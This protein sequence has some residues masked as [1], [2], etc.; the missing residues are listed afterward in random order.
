VH[1]FGLVREQLAAAR[2]AGLPFEQAWEAVLAS[3]PSTGSTLTDRYLTSVALRETME[4]W[5]AAY[6]RRP[7][8][9][10]ESLVS[11]PPVADEIEARYLGPEAAR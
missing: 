2:R 1:E 4:A 8:P 5:K 6:E 7:P 3:H 10:G 11:P 9:E